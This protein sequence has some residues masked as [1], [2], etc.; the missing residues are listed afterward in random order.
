MLEAF[1]IGVSATAILFGLGML[2]DNIQEATLLRRFRK[3]TFYGPF[4][5]DR[6]SR[7]I[8]RAEREKGGRKYDYPEGPVYP[9]TEW[10]LHVCV[11]RED[12]DRKFAHQL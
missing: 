4:R 1:L 7:M 9:N 10:N 12:F 6:C 2:L 5:C 8:A 3:V 11:T